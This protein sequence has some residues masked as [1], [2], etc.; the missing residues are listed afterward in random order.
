MKLEFRVVLPEISGTATRNRVVLPEFR[1]ALSKIRVVPE[2][3]VLSIY[4]LESKKSL[5][6]IAVQH[7]APKRI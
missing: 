2:F 3:R 7:A 1:V 4:Y 5:L 6:S